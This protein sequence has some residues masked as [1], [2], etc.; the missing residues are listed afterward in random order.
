MIGYGFDQRSY[1]CLD[2]Q[3]HKLYLFRSVVFYETQFLAIHGFLSNATIQSV[4]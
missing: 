4:Y 2:P 1:G 3:T